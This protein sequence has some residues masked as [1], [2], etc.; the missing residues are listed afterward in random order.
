MGFMRRKDL[1]RKG[2][3]TNKDVDGIHNQKG[4]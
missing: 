3:E 4:S 1:L 2:E